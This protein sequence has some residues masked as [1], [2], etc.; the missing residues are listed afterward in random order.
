MKYETHDMYTIMKVVLDYYQ[1]E[2]IRQCIVECIQ[3]VVL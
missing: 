3:Y 2:T 1:K